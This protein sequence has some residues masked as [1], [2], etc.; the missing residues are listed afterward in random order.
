MA[1]RSRIVRYGVGVCKPG[2]SL[3]LSRPVVRLA[4]ACAAQRHY[5]THTREKP[6]VCTW[7]GCGKTFTQAAG[8][9]VALCPA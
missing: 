2:F 4:L 5:R 9:N 8:L 1:G 3:A 6:F 7:R